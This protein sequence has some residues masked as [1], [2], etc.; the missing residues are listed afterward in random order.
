MDAA[1]TW[2][3]RALVSAASRRRVFTRCLKCALFLNPRHC[4]FL[5]VREDVSQDIR[6]SVCRASSCKTGCRGF[7]ALPASLRVIPCWELR[8]GAGRG[9]VRKDPFEQNRCNC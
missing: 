2:P 7:S 4:L 5:S 6:T 9:A 8:L 1:R 3:G